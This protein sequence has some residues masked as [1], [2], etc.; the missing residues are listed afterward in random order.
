MHSPT[1]Q[2]T[3]CASHRVPQLVA[4]FTAPWCWCVQAALCAAHATP[5]TQRA[6]SATLHTR[7]SALQALCNDI[8]GKGFARIW[9]THV[10]MGTFL[11]VFLMLGVWMCHGMNHLGGRTDREQY[12][13]KLRA[14]QLS[15]LAGQPG[16]FAVSQHKHTPAPATEVVVNPA[17]SKP[18]AEV[19][20]QPLNN[21]PQYPVPDSTAPQPGIASV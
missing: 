14:Q 9:A 21:A 19:E 15:D 10:A 8:V 13:A 18:G 7:R 5:L 3:S 17:G 2:M 20:M 11:I 12:R 6:T 16:T 4:A 1:L